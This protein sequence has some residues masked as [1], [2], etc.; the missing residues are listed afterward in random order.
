MNCN[1]LQLEIDLALKIMYEWVI[2]RNHR[3]RFN[4]IL[5]VILIMAI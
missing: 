4:A 5:L 2:R 3:T 1:K